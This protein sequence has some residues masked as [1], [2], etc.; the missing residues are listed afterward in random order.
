MVCTHDVQQQ[1]TS[2][3]FAT[4]KKPC[5]FKATRVGLEIPSA[6]GREPM[7][8]A[9]ICTPDVSPMTQPIMVPALARPRVSPR[10]KAADHIQ[11]AFTTRLG[12]IFS[13]IAP[14]RSTA[15]STSTIKHAA[16]VVTFPMDCHHAG[17]HL[18]SH[19]YASQAYL[20]ASQHE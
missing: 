6:N 18:L 20:V 15:A 7:P 16:R 8:Q 10:W 2:S 1:V 4:N 14:D 9:A 5:Q 17:T 3:K 11:T 19:Q 13:S 12:A